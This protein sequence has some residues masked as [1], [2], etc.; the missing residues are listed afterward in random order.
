M[1]SLRS[2]LTTLYLKHQM[3]SK[4]LHLLDPEVLR[5]GTDNIGL[6]KPPKGMSLETVDSGGVRGEWHKP[7]AIEDGRTVLFFHGGGYV[8]G[9][10]KSHRALTFR[11]G[12]LSA[13]QVFSSDYRLAPEHPFPAA[14]EDGLAALKWVYEQG[15]EPANLTI[16][17]DSAGGGLSLAVM[18]AAKQE[19]APLPA[20]AVLY[21]PFTDLAVTGNSMV[22]NE[23]TDAMF[24][25]DYIV[26]GAARYLGEA[27]A[28]DPLA[29]PLYGDLSGLPPMLI[30]AS[31]SEVLLDDSVR[32][33]ERA[34]AAGVDSTLIVEHGLPHVW[35][36]FYPNFPEA[37][38]SIK[39][40]AEFIRD[41]A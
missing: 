24:K 3:K 5:E 37:D 11:F 17:G 39:E 26:G 12:E 8:F 15:V 28:K 34:G 1:P 13:A 35:P 7:S 10:P 31:D 29:S 14:V 32:L 36:L 40:S 6:K 30:F 20:A 18:L 16:A 22:S 21:S 41:R 38:R 19:K 25:R 2:K 27:D 23:K 9:S 33:H 4:P